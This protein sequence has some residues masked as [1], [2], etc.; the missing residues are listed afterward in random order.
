[1]S[2][3]QWDHKFEV[4]HA[5]IDAQHRAL[6]ELI[7]AVAEA[8]AADASRPQVLRLVN[9]L[10]KYAEYHFVSEENLM[11]E[12]GYPDTARHRREH[13]ILVARLADQI[14]DF[15]SGILR[16]EKIV[17]YLVE[18]FTLHAMQEDQKLASHLAG[19]NPP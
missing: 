3:V 13:A 19:A 9:E 2:A 17:A 6:L 18:W 4:G 11:E 1:M 12:S 7:N 16:A 10:T 5:R 14:Q 8:S 15:Q